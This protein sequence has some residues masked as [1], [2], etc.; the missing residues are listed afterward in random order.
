M[1]AASRRLA[2]RLAS[3]HRNPLFE[4]RVGGTLAS[5]AIV[6][7]ATARL[8]CKNIG[9]RIGGL[10]ALLLLMTRAIDFLLTWRAS[11]RGMLLF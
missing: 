7:C 2:Q 5:G 10:A 11:V 4:R 6:R 9:Y 3:K 8:Q 1:G